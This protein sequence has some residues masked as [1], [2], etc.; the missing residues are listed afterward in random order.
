[1]PGELKAMVCAVS[2]ATE[3]VIVLET[4]VAAAKTPLPTWLASTLQVPAAT[5]VSVLPLAVQTPGL[6]DAKL[7]ARPELALAT[8]ASGAPPKV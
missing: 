4:V 6:V 2:G 7:T 8:S 1:M 3:T 5:S